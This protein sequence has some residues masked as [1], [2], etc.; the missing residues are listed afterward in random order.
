MNVM[1]IESKSVAPSERKPVE[2]MGANLKLLRTS[3]GMTQKMLAEKLERGQDYVSDL[4]NKKKFKEEELNNI[5]RVMEVHPDYFKYF[6]MEEATRSYKIENNS[7]SINNTSE[8]GCQEIA[9]QQGV[10]VIESQNVTNIFASEELVQVY[11]DLVI[12]KDR[13][14]ELLRKQLQLLE[15]SK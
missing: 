1:E 8:E 2:H 4:E 12:E 11:K 9:S 6:R 10:Q 3:M 7:I 14:I 15:E 13:V 5:A